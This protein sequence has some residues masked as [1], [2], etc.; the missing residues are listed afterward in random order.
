MVVH[1]IVL[2]SDVVT[3]LECK[4]TLWRLHKDEID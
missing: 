4:H 2:P 1:K 3:D